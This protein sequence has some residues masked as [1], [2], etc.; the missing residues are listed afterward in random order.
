MEMG[1]VGDRLGNLCE[2][3]ESSG[4]GLFLDFLMKICQLRL[5]DT[6]ACRK[7]F[8]ARMSTNL[9][10]VY[11]RHVFTTLTHKST[12]PFFDSPC[13]RSSFSSNKLAN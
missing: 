13:H 7:M 9:L 2:Q 11:G 5:L 10:D 8:A 3:R 6:R 1:S 12:A 4:P